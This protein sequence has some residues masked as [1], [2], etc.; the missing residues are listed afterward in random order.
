MEDYMMITTIDQVEQGEK[1]HLNQELLIRS[2]N[3][4]SIKLV[5]NER[6]VKEQ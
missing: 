5:K 1:G 4:L 6:V 2:T 3:G